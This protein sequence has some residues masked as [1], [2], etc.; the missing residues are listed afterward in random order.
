MVFNDPH[1]NATIIPPLMRMCT[2]DLHSTRKLTRES[3]RITLWVSYSFESRLKEINIEIKSIPILWSLHKLWYIQ[4]ISTPHT[5]TRRFNLLITIET[6]FFDN[7]Y[8]SV[9]TMFGSTHCIP[10]KS[11]VYGSGVSIFIKLCVIIRRVSGIKT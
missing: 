11:I 6:R 4:Y 1:A 5:A 7:K 2:F 8:Q 10:K 3:L 9:I